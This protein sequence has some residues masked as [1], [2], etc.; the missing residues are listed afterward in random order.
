MS[1]PADND[2]ASLL[3]GVCLCMQTRGPPKLPSSKTLL[4]DLKLLEE[5][6]GFRGKDFL[7]MGSWI[8]YSYMKPCVYI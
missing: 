2:S 7:N 1:S 4:G 8:L 3:P 6:V 5:Q